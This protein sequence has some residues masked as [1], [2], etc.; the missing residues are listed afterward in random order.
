MSSTN[1]VN[2]YWYKF[3]WRGVL[4][5]EST[6]RANDKVG[7]QME[8]AHALQLGRHHESNKSYVPLDTKT[9]PGS[10]A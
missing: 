6:K 7:R 9:G 2:I 1:A 5:R 10:P 4:V 3:M 8:A